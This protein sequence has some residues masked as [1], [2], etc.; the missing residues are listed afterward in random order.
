MIDCT[1]DHRNNIRRQTG[2][3]TCNKDHRMQAASH[4]PYRPILPNRHVIQPSGC[5]AERRAM[6]RENVDI[7]GA[8]WGLHVHIINIEKEERSSSKIAYI[9]TANTFTQG[10]VYEFYS[11]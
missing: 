9:G 5:S 1:I 8:A 7:N 2:Q 10:S 3:V 4:R 11:N 6:F